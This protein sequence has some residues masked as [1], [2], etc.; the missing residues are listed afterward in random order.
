M[1]LALKVLVGHCDL[2][3]S[4]VVRK[5]AFCICENKD[6]D[7]L[8]GNREADQHLCFR[9]NPVILHFIWRLQSLNIN[10]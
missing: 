1:M 3:L 4:L 8:H 5:P 2:Y 6:T 7:Q 10:I 9:Y